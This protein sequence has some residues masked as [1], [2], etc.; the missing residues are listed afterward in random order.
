MAEIPSLMPEQ[1]YNPFAEG[2]A[3][4]KLPPKPPAAELSPGAKGILADIDEE[5]AKRDPEEKTGRLPSAAVLEKT[6]PIGGIK[7]SRRLQAEAGLEEAEVIEDGE[8]ELEGFQTHE[9]VMQQQQM[10]AQREATDTQ[11][12]GLEGIDPHNAAS[13]KEGTKRVVD[14][15][16]GSES[17]QQALEVQL[18][19]GT[20]KLALERKRLE[21]LVQDKV[22]AAAFAL[23]AKTMPAFRIVDDLRR[24][25]ANLARKL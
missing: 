21:L 6:M 22:R 18:G 9:T 25:I 7:E 11:E 17:D 8:P 15:F 24:D 19:L 13:L 3:K 10:R 1:G 2:L 23:R 16:L 12:S 5:L 14:S 20:G 4:S